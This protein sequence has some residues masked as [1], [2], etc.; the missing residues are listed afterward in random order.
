MS[1][2]NQFHTPP[3]PSQAP[4]LL[5][6]MRLRPLVAKIRK[7]ARG[8]RRWVGL[9]IPKQLASR[10]ELE[11]AL[12]EIAVLGD[13]WRLYDFVEQNAILRLPLAVYIEARPILE[14][15]VDGITSV[16]A[17][18]KIRLVRN[19]LGIERPPRKR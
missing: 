19:R 3:H 7:A 6:P 17:S 10:E 4:F 18:G 8:K 1:F 9:A 5:R 14:A 15:G 11:A 2:I 13:D 12:G 16:T